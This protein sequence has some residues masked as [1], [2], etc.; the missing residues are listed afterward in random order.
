VARAIG[1]TADRADAAPIAGRA[2][3]VE[4]RNASGRPGLARQV[5]RLLREKGVDVISFGTA[6]EPADSTTVL[7]RRGDQSRGHQ[8]ARMLG[9]ARVVMAPDTLVRLD[10]T[11]VL[12][13]DYQLPKDRFP[14]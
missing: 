7:V 4:V 12:G 2:I 13:A 6:G 5:T 9:R 8:V 14:L 10:L 11:V 1:G 3:V